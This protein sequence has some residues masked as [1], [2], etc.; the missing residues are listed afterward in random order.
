MAVLF[1]SEAKLHDS[2]G[3]CIPHSTYQGHGPLYHYFLIFMFVYMY[4]TAPASTWSPY[5]GP[6]GAFL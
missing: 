1:S 6:Q 5:Y 4:S 2:D 3:Y